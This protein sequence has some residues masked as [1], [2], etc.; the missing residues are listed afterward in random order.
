[1]CTE[2]AKHEL[3]H[4][5]ASAVLPIL[6]TVKNPLHILAPITF[7]PSWLLLHLLQILNT[8]LAQLET[9]LLS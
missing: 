3:H 9:G 8:F 5:L 2:L 4:H 1:M 6:A 7:Y